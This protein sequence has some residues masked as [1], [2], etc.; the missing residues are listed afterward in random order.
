MGIII[1]VGAVILVGVGGCVCSIATAQM[2][3]EKERH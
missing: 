2:Y 1:V 3:Q